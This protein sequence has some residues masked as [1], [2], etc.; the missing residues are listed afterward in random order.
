MLLPLSL[1]TSAMLTKNK[2]LQLNNMDMK[3]LR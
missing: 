1:K 2:D 3:E